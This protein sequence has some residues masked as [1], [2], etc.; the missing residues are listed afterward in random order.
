MA[1]IVLQTAGAFIGGLFGPVGAVLGRAAGALAGYS[2]DRSLI[3]STQRFEGP[4]MTAQRPFSAEEGAPIPRVFGTVRVGGSLIW[5]TRFEEQTR[6]ERQGGKGGGPK[7]TSYSYFANAAF[8]LCEGEIAGVRRIWADGREIERDKVTIRVH[9]GTQDQAPDPLIAAKQGS[10]NAPAY[11]GLA[12]VVID[13]LPIAD[14]GNRL[15]QFQFEVLRPVGSL[16][17]D[18]RAVT[19][20]PGSTEYGLWTEPVR[21]QVRPGETRH[22]NRNMLHGPTDIVASLDELQALCPNLEHVSLVVSWFGDD[23]RAGTC[24]IR[25]MVTTNEPAPGAPAWAVNGV[26]R[27]AAAEVSQVEGRAAYGGTP[28]D[29]SVIQAIQELK[30]RGLKVT[31]HPFIMMDVPAG[32]DLSDPYGGEGQAAYPWRGRITCHPAPGVT[33]SVDG[34][35]AAAAQLAAFVGSATAG[36]VGVGS[37]G[38]TYSGPAGD[39]GFR[40]F[41]LHHARLAQA[42]GG[43]EAFFIGS[44]MRGVSTIRDATGGY[45]F[46]TALVA[47]AA[48]VKAILGST[49]ITY[50][51]DWSEYFGHQPADGS[52]DVTFHLDPLWA[53]PAIAAVGIDNYMPLSDW[54]DADYAGGNPDGAE[55]PY[56]GE[57]LGRAVARGEGFDWYYADGTSR[58]ARERLPITDQEYGKP[59]VFRAKDLVAW[60]SNPHHDRIGGVEVETPTAWVPRSKPIWFTELGCPAVDKGPNQPNVFPDPKSSEHA[61]PAASDGGRSDAAQ[62]AFLAAHFKHWQDPST[63]PV[64]NLYGAPMVDF[65]RLYLW[66]WDARPYP[67]FPQN[68]E[69]WADGAAWQTGHWLNGRLS[70]AG[71]QDLIAE[72][73]ADAGLPPARFDA[74][75]GTVQGFMIEEPASARSVLEPLCDLFGVVALEDE[76]FL[77]FIGAGLGLSNATA[78]DDMV[79][80]D[81]EAP[82]IE[83]QRQP[84]DIVPGEVELGYRDPTQDHQAAVARIVR[85]SGRRV[86]IGFAGT[87]EP[88]QAEALATDWL[89]RQVAG[90]ETMRFAVPPNDTAAALG[91]V[92]EVADARWRVT[93]LEDGLTRQVEAVRLVPAMPTPWRPNG[94]AS[95]SSPPLAGPPHVLFLDLPMVSD[96]VAPEARFMIAARARPWRSQVALVSPGEDGFAS[97]ATILWP[98]AMGR[99]M[100]DLP[101]AA[102]G[103][104]GDGVHVDVELFEGELSSATRLRVLNGANIAAVQ[105]ISGVWE[106]LQFER[107]EEIEPAVW[108]VSGLL[109]GQLGTEDA[110]LSGA[111]PGADFVVLDEALVPAGLLGSEAGLSLNW[112][113]GPVGDDL[114]SGNFTDVTIEGGLR[115]RRPLSPVHLKA[116]Q[117]PDGSIA[118]EWVRRGRID[119]DGWDGADIPLGEEREAY[120]LE[121][122]SEEAVLRS[123]EVASPAWSYPAAA[124]AADFGATPATLDLRVQQIGALAGLPARRTISIQ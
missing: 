97:R 5:A 52:G 110:S 12:Y 51:A 44:E 22:I 60:W 118:I 49:Q 8:A 83:R 70:G 27:A 98:A 73:I 79:V 13:R 81:D 112:K 116:K 54:R 120:L 108:R 87:M 20:I 3:A 121:V 88:G 10:G 96:A 40:R 104:I 4:R 106:V 95:V 1:T 123:A 93:G 68:G 11:R 26:S 36:Q 23:L 21:W 122:M 65:Q 72:V 17:K 71:I 86:S 80:P 59:W 94:R 76:G 37:A 66:C 100:G 61:T 53:S 63:N 46:V 113:V 89:A 124:V 31:L 33:G 42:A 103:R 119:A 77:T 6:T 107:A 18:V 38:T 25:P 34:T 56:D 45:P 47:L 101:G 78:I 74:V 29:R 9:R 114:A 2:I 64:S 105:S 111:P 48:D 91:R 50:A 39:W 41:V 32:N 14:Y 85:G 99:L 82:T 109:R 15:P 92:I 117:Q 58:R 62:Q 84:G 28:S 69:L 30:A 19:L 102:S 43:V 57:A 55:G 7:V 90:R 16:H 35:P 67:A 75:S 115:A 24:R